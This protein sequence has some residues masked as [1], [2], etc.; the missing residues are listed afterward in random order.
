MA[1]GLLLLAAI[2]AFPSIAYAQM[3]VCAQIGCIDGLILRSDPSR[4][5]KDGN[6]TFQF[7]LD[8]RHVKCWGELPL[9]PCGEQSLKCDKEGVM[10]LESGC[11]LPKNQ[12][13]FGDIMI[14]RDPSKVMLRITHNN[15]PIVTKTIARVDY[16]K[17]MPNGAGCGPVCRSAA[18]NIFDTA[19]E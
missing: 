4:E 11:A 15:K 10:I 9:K 1:R 8:N 6:Y 14:D 13:G 19:E 2:L 5:W 7:V 3:Q 12:H 16:Q 17:S 18:Y